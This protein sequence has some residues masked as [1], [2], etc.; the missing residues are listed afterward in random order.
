MYA[1]RVN[2]TRKLDDLPA[3]FWATGQ[4][5]N[6]AITTNLNQNVTNPFNISNFSSLQ[7]SNPVLYQALASTPFFS[8]PTI[9]KSQLLRAFPQMN[10]LNQILD[11]IGETKGHSLEVVFQRRMSKG[12]TINFS[13]TATYERDRDFFYNEFDA[14]PSWRL[15][16]NAAPQRIAATGIY[17]LPFGKSKP[18]LRTGIPSKLLGGF[19]IALTFETEPGPYLTWGNVFY[20]GNI[21]DITA[22]YGSIHNTG[23]GRTLSTWF[24]TAGFETN[25]AKTP[26]A[27]NLRT[28]PSRVGGL[29]ANGLNK[30]D[31]NIQRQFH[32]LEGLR[33]E[34]RADFINLFNHTQFA[35]P[36]LNPTA[37]DFGVV[38]TN[39]ATVSR[40]LLFQG[41]FLF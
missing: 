17:E 25:P 8:S 10:G 38:T 31:G 12:F 4:V 34:V 24:N 23:L 7:S 3:Q 13:Y 32:V 29:R 20:Y 36:G 39:S 21:R 14:L 11:P 30:W 18:L 16:N 22:G 1:D 37:T 35:P 2:V 41:R 27:F 15:S 33:F 26:D 5:R 9:R 28:F 40:Y 19:Q 6:N